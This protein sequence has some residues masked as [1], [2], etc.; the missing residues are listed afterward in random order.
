MGRKNMLAAIDATAFI[1]Y[2][3]AAAESMVAFHARTCSRR[4]MATAEQKPTADDARRSALMAA[5][6]AGEKTA[7]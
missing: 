2:S 1:P 7:Y 5:A 6:Q 4:R 3:G